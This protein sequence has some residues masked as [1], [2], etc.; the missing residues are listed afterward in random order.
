MKTPSVYNLKSLKLPCLTGW[1]LRLFAL[2]LRNSATRALLMRD[3]F[4]R[5][6]VLKFRK[7]IISEPPA[8]HPLTCDLQSP[9]AFGTD[10]ER[11]FENDPLN[12]G[13]NNKNYFNSV[14]D[15]TNAYRAGTTTPEEIAEKVLNAL[16]E[17]SS[18]DPPLHLFIACDRED[19]L[20]QAREATRRIQA[21]N[22]LSVLDGVPVAVKDELDQVP[23]P[24]TGGT[25]FLGKKP[26]S[27]DAT[28]V[29]RLRA[30]GALL[31]GKTN[32]HEIGINPNGLNDH[33]GTVRNPYHPAHDSGGSSSGSTAAVASGIC[34]VAIGA[35][36][37]GSIRVPAAHCGVVGLKPTFGRISEHGTVP[38]CWSLAHLGPI[39]I[40]T[41]D[42]ALTY[43]FIAGPDPDDPMSM[44]QPEVT[45]DEWNKADLNGLT[46]GVYPE[47]FDHASP[48]VTS[49]CKTM[50]GQL[51]QNGAL[52]RNIEI[53]E[54]DEMRI[55]HA[56][57]ILSEMAAS[58][59]NHREHRYDFGASVQVSLALG[60]ALASSDYI[61]AQRMRM[62]ASR[63]FQ[64]ILAEVDVI[65]TPTTAITAPLI[66][67]GGLRWGWSDL[68][69]VTEQMRFVF[70]GNLIGLPAI[71]FPVGYDEKGLPIGMQAIGRPWEE[72]VLLRVAYTAEQ[73]VAR[74]KPR[75][76]F[77]TLD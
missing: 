29:A 34:P 72:Q 76:F 7:K 1:V 53:P 54:L 52:T 4:K 15:Y 71:S 67:S 69:T 12:D 10:G 6:G 17:A 70:P 49:A 75:I 20:A 64:K 30:V 39:G 5:A 23:Y 33:Y 16:A 3:L 62:R 41:E 47:W 21:G 57:T 25:T 19:V 46:I 43:A 65:L 61:R 40:S 14:R 35:D 36:G 55:A 9:S 56:I 60:R 37:G 42:V 26:A 66:P 44:G 50:L 68:S 45:L 58:M 32:M 18:L 59:E 8:Y 48:S 63:I 31:I 27:R 77:E 2:A 28:V 11:H 38:L 74:K 73:Y 51:E 13:R 22:S 24:T